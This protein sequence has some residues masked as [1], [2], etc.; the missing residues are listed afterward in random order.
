MTQQKHLKRLVRARMEKTGESYATA[1]R[2]VIRNAPPASG[3]PATRWHF[4]GNVPA[5]T[6]L[7]VLLAHAGV[8]DPHTGEPF[9]E[10]MLF[11]IAGGIGIGVFSFFYE[12]AN[13]ASFFVAGR[14]E[15]QDDLGY[16]KHACERF[17][18]T[19]SVRESSGAKSAEKHLREALAKGPC[20]A[21]VDMV[22]LPHRAMPQTHSG[23]GYHVVTVYKADDATATI[24]D[25]T[26]QPIEIP[27]ANLAEARARIKKQKNRLLSV[28]GP[29]KAPDVSTLVRAGLSACVQKLQSPTMKAARG[30]FQ[31]DALKTWA[32][33]L[34]GSKDKERW[35]RVFAPGANLLRG[36]TGV[37]HW[38][39]YYGTGGG[40]CR[41]LFADFFTE[42][43]ATLKDRRLP[44]I[45]QQY[46]HL[47]RQWTELADAALPDGVPMFREA[48]ALLARRA[49]LLVS[50]GPSATTEIRGVWNRLGELERQATECFP[51]S[52]IQCADLR[53]SLKARVLAIHQGEITALAAVADAMS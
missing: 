46:S 36:L 6:A 52:D 45:A 12:K 51:L 53:A 35:E 38:I 30:N 19:S 10:P 40:L 31:L 23:G 34:H 1:R 42:A 13:H 26:D 24:G 15:L 11:G 14:H 7:R 29:A 17:G 47:G 49:E 4:P 39:E 8:R 28:T 20:V 50:E 33:R 44:D 43:A 32:E 5:T 37:H 41:P 22:H 48:K 9:S 2:Q 27:L 21:W 16:L 3:D 25:L 18:L